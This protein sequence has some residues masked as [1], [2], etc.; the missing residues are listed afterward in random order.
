MNLPQKFVVL[1]QP[2]TGSTLVCSLLSSH[3][4]VRTIIEP[5]NPRGHDHHMKPVKGTVCLLPEHMIQN[6]L[7]RALDI[8]FS[9]KPI[10]DQWVLSQRSAPQ[11]AGFKIMAHQLIALRSEPIFWNYLREN[12]VKIIL[13]FRY[14]IIM[15]YVS[16]LIVQ[17]TRESTCW[18]GKPKTAKVHVPIPTLGKTLAKISK[19]KMYLIEKTTQFDH[20]RVRYEDFKDSV[21]PIEQ[22]MPWLIG[23]EYNLTTR[24]Q[25]Q[26]PDNLQARVKNYGA[27]VVELRRLG[28]GH[29][30]KI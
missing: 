18:A 13:V 22:L 25:K 28:L 1:S 17:Q 12:K 14:N 26:N 19:Q 9:S 30:T 24:L 2:R 20:R 29:L 3:P 21:E 23:E 8:L 27:L 16:D 11:A 7:P 4:G 5:I 10:P 15:Q 6:N